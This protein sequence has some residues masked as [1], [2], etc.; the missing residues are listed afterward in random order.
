MLRKTVKWP[1]KKWGWDSPTIDFGFMK[2]TSSLACSQKHDLGVGQ[3]SCSGA[4]DPGPI[5]QVDILLFNY[6]LSTPATGK[7]VIYC[8]L[9]FFF[10]HSLC[11]QIFMCT[12]IKG[13]VEGANQTFSPVLCSQV[14]WTLAECFVSPGFHQESRAVAFDGSQP[15][16]CTDPSSL[17]GTW[18]GRKMYEGFHK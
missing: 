3:L 16:P 1:L 5:H 7:A 15:V 8:K 6:F 4:A 9:V 14:Q 18:T 12:V 11:S 13:P 17:W 10:L 2:R